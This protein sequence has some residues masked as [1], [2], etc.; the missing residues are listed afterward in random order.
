MVNI[1]ETKGETKRKN[2]M[3]EAWD[4]RTLPHIEVGE[5]R[6]NQQT[7]GEAATKGRQGTCRVMKPRD[8]G[9]SRES[10]CQSCQK[11]QIEKVRW[12]PRNDH[13]WHWWEQGGVEV[14]WG[15][16]RCDLKREGWKKNWPFSVKM[17]NFTVKGRREW[18]SNW[19]MKRGHE[20]PFLFVVKEDPH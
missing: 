15:V 10:R 13:W 5:M 4:L 9:V 12:W 7:Y 14:G 6:R 16:Y 3:D 8:G 20:R 2:E 18:C 19:K 11:L 1:D 17:G